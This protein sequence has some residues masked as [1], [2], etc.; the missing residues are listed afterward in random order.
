[1]KAYP[2]Y[3]L[4]HNPFQKEASHHV[5]MLDYKEMVFRLEGLIQTKGLGVFTG[6]SGFGKTHT[7]KQ[8]TN[9]LNPGLYKVCY[10][11]MSTLTV[12]DFY[13]SLAIGL[14]LEPRHR[15]IDLF[16]QI[17]ERIEALH[18]NQKITPVIVLDEA[19]YLKVSVLQDITMLLNFE[20]DSQNKCI[21]ILSGLPNLNITL[22]RAPLEPLRQR[23]LRNYNMQ[24]LGKEDLINYIEDK[25]K[26]A[27]RSA[28]LF[29]GNAYEA[30][31]SHAQGSIRKLNNLITQTMMIGELRNKNILDA[32]DVF[33]ANNEMTVI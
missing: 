9:A 16:K 17:Q 13:R 31:N 15:K 22:T 12:M 19:Q 28:P 2:Y 6:A 30:L 8:F 27:G 3:G 5:E 24:G 29:E 20:M 33:E 21:V 1:M 32:D 10:Y 26:S 4:S 25:L 14:G 18:D 7:L 23:V 11:S